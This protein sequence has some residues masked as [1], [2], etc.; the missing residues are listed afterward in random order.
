MN[1]KDLRVYQQSSNLFPRLYGLVKSWSVFDQRSIGGQLVRSV[2]SIHANI[3]EGNSKSAKDY[4]RFIG[5]AIASCD[6]SRSHLM[7]SYNVKLI[8]RD[9]YQ[10]YDEELQSIGKQLTNLKKSVNHR[11]ITSP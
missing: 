6:E 1:F 2:N 3:A 10:K 4:I 9:V 8:D 11:I 7:D 5:I